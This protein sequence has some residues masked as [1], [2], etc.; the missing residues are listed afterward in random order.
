MSIHGPNRRRS[1]SAARDSHRRDSDRPI[2]LADINEFKH[3]I[4][5]ERKDKKRSKRRTGKGGPGSDTD[6]AARQLSVRP[7]LALNERQQALYDLLTDHPQRPCDL[8]RALGL[9]DGQL[10]AAMGGLTVRGVA[11]RTPKGWRRDTPP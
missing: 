1:I 11:I 5:Q 10:G 8:R 6:R 9:T 3:M 2:T 7:T 4:R